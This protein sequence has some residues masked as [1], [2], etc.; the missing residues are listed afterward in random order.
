MWAVLLFFQME[1]ATVWQV[2]TFFFPGNLFFLSV[3][4]CQRLPYNLSW[5]GMN[6][7]FFICISQNMKLRQR[8]RLFD[9]SI[10]AVHNSGAHLHSGAP[11]SDLWLKPLRVTELRLLMGAGQGRPH[12]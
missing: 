5:A 2:F 11:L 6:V 8:K 4:L 3:S 10:S 7:K 1:T 9:S 12:L